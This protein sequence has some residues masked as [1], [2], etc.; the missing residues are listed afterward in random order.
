MIYRG[1]QHTVVVVLPVEVP[2]P[3]RVWHGSVNVIVGEQPIAD[4]GEGIQQA[5]GKGLLL[6]T[7]VVTGVA[8]RGLR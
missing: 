2:N 6:P 8:F 5:V 1:T 7:K 3:D 4:D